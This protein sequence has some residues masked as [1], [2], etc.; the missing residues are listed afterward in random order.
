MKKKT[1]ALLLALVLVVGVAAGGTMAWLLDKTDS[2]TNTFTAGDVAITLSET[3]PENDNNAANNSYKMVP[4]ATISKDPKVTVTDTSESC[5]VFV[6]LTKSDN[7]DT[8]MTYTVADGWTQGTG[9]GEGGNGV[10][11]NVYYRTVNATDTTR[12]F[13]VLSGDTVSVK[14]DVTKAQLNAVATNGQPTL[15][16]TAYACQLAKTSTENFTVGDAWTQVSGL[17]NSGNE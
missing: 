2:I 6:E 12:T 4:G 1:V 14:S 10:P 9:D 17:N 15:T 13:S 7:F 16:V 5:Y 8:F 3:D 11:T